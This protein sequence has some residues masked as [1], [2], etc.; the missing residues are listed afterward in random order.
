VFNDLSTMS[1]V[2]SEIFSRG[3]YTG[4][5]D[6]FARYGF[7]FNEPIGVRIASDGS[8]IPLNYGEMKIKDGLY[9][10]IPRTGPR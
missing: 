10:L 3:V 4:T 6:G 2:E 8:R 5:R 7:R 1:R 9:H